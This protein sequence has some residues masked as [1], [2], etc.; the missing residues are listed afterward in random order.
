LIKV[1]FV[2][3]IACPNVH[4]PTITIFL[5]L[6]VFTG[7]VLGVS[8][9]MVLHVDQEG[10][11]SIGIPHLLHAHLHAEDADHGLHDMSSDADHCHLHDLI[12]AIQHA[13]SAS[14]KTECGGLIQVADHS[15]T[16]SDAAL[17]AFEAPM[18]LERSL[19]AVMTDS[20]PPRAIAERVQ[21]ASLRAII[22]LS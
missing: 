6:S 4:R 18:V 17:L 19:V 7:G 9:G 11:L 1:T 10:H 15:D 22:L 3:S 12:G 5:C 13:T 8:N 20:G 2:T 14:R 21:R 16:I